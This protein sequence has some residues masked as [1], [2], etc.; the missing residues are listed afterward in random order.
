M[1]NKGGRREQAS[2]STGG[3]QLPAGGTATKVSGRTALEPPAPAT[4]TREQTASV[5]SPFWLSQGPPI[6]LTCWSS[7]RASVDFTTQEQAADGLSSSIHRLIRLFS[8]P[9]A[10]CNSKPPEHRASSKVMATE[11]PWLCRGK[12][13]RVRGMSH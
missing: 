9:Q 1:R 2:T 7:S 3:P 8:T 13:E 10:F 4:P 6:M 11:L 12:Q 5:D